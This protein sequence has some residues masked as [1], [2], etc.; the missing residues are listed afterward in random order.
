MVR[1]EMRWLGA[2]LLVLIA[3][4]A[5]AQVLN[6]DEIFKSPNLT[7]DWGG[8]RPKLEDQ[9]IQLGGDEILGTLGTPDGGVRGRWTAGTVR[10][11]GNGQ[12]V[13]PVRSDLSRQCLSDPWRGPD[14]ARSEQPDHGQQYRGAAF[15]QAVRSLAP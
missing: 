6:Y 12:G 7:G 11:C 15:H 4:P 2:F 5:R 1:T 10:Q 9:G 8:V 14:L 13:W 3:S